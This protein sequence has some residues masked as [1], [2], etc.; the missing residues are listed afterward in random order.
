VRGGDH[1]ANWAAQGSLQP[2]PISSTAQSRVQIWS[3]A[4]TGRAAP[5][6]L[7]DGDEPA[8]APAG[9]RVAFVKDRRI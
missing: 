5:K 8:I 9:D 6:L 7:S 1:G 3:I 4:T 2:N